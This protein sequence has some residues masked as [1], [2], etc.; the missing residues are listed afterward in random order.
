M[1]LFANAAGSR[2][3]KVVFDEKELSMIRIAC[4]SVSAKDQDLMDDAAGA[5]L[6]EYA[7]QA[8][9][10]FE[11]DMAHK[12]VSLFKAGQEIIIEP[13]DLAP[14]LESLKNGKFSLPEEH[15]AALKSAI[16]KIEV[17]IQVP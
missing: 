11:S 5:G 1:S 15:T 3:G 13:E 16:A 14:V 8:K 17:T 10:A 9:K 7:L 6:E 12:L 2:Y 4:A